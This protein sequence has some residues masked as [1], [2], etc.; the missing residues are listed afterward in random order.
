MKKNANYTIAT[1]I[2]INL[3][4]VTDMTTKA[5][6][7]HTYNYLEMKTTILQLQIFFLQYL[8]HGS[9]GSQCKFIFF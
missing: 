2:R 6:N 5:I 9:R 8:M 7:N 1:F 4:V 3:L